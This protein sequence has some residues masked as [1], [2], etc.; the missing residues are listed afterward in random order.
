MIF[1]QEVD[2]CLAPAPPHADLLG[3]DG[4]EY[5]RHGNTVHQGLWVDQ[6]EALGVAGKLKVTQCDQSG[7]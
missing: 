4:R 7:E 3:K 1:T 5:S 2:L 6:P